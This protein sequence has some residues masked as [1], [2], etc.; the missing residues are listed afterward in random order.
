MAAPLMTTEQLYSR[1]PDGIVGIG[2]ELSDES[3][4]ACTRQFSPKTHVGVTNAKV[5]ASL[6]MSGLGVQA[7]V[8]PRSAIGASL[9]NT[10]SF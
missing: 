4:C 9:E 2:V 3:T 6:L 10:M 5:L 8:P 1:D 7:G